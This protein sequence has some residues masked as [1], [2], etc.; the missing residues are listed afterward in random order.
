MSEPIYGMCEPGMMYLGW[1]A[2]TNPDIDRD[3]PAEPYIKVKAIAVAHTGD[4]PA[5]WYD[6]DAAIADMARFYDHD[7]EERKAFFDLPLP[8]LDIFGAKNA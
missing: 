1:D 5:Q 4:G 3:I 6:H 7:S 2:M 8:K